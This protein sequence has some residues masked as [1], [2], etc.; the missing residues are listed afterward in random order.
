MLAALK[1]RR[2]RR[3]GAPSSPSFP[4]TATDGDGHDGAGHGAGD[5]EDGEEGEEGGEEEEEEEEEDEEGEGGEGEEEDAEE[6]NE[7]YLRG[8]LDADLEDFVIE[9]TPAD[10]LG[11]PD[12]D[13]ASG[14]AALPL[15]FTAASHASNRT[16]FQIYAESLVCDA[17]FPGLV[18]R[19]AKVAN[20][21]RR[22][23]DRVTVLN[24]S[25]VTSGAWTPA[26]TRALRARPGLRIMPCP[27]TGHCDACNRNRQ[28]CTHR[29]RFTGHRY[30]RDTLSDLDS[31]G[32]DAD[33]ADDTGEQLARESAEFALGS[34]CFLRA[35]SAH[36]LAH[37]RKELRGW[38]RA[39]LVRN[40]V[41]REDGAVADPAVLQYS[42]Q[43]PAPIT[44]HS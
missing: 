4:D 41:L 39:T 17:L 30:N 18:A 35:R 8:D 7:A 20:A 34:S 33:S 13:D 25:V 44:H 27:P 28:Q 1:A 36:V 3:S 21:L 24:Q 16:Q 37:W 11:A 9:D 10:L 38:L 19:D 26:F 43:G 22:L 14:D 12:D 29:V 42:D 2:L 15:Q 31:D 32:S 40:G 6:D 5:D 23:Q